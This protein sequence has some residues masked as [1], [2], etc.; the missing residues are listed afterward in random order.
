VYQLSA[1][2]NPS[3]THQDK[4]GPHQTMLAQHASVWSI[5]WPTKSSVNVTHHN[6][7][8][9]MACAIQRTSWPPAMDAAHTALPD[10]PTSVDQSTTSSKR[11]NSTVAD[12]QSVLTSLCAVVSVPVHLSSHLP[13]D[14]SRSNA[15]AVVLSRQ[16]RERSTWPVQMTPSRHTPMKL[17]QSVLVTQHL[18]MPVTLRTKQLRGIGLLKQP[19]WQTTG[20]DIQREINRFTLIRYWFCQFYICFTFF[21][22]RSLHFSFPTLSFVFIIYI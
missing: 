14:D 16:R 8:Q 17:L 4:H 9:L 22:F 3:N 1:T 21:A 11:L 10:K 15:H 12:P 13:L 2:T 5:Q 7:H 20:L 19:E 6:V 18:A